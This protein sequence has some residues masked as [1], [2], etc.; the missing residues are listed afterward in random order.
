MEQLLG[1]PEMFM[2]YGVLGAIV[3]YFMR[4]VNT[5]LRELRV[6]IDQLKIVIAYCPYNKKG[7]GSDELAG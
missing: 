5:T 1:N 6:T 4:L 3:V 2:Q 7:G